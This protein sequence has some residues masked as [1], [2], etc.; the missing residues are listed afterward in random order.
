MSRWRESSGT[1]LGSQI[2]PPAESSWGK[3]CERRQKFWKS[4][5]VASR[6]TSPS[7]TNGGPYTDPNAIASPPTCRLCSGL[8]AWSSNSFGA[9]ATCSITKSGSSQTFASSVR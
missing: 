2:V 9:F 1:S 8:R 3:A 4:A 6:R 5:I 7:R